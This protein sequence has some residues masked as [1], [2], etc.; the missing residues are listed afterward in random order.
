MNKTSWQSLN[1]HY[2]KTRDR[3]ITSLFDDTARFDDFSVEGVDL[4]LDYSKTN[5][6]TFTKKKLLQLV[7]IKDVPKH[8]NNMFGGSIINVSENRPAL[9]IALRSTS[10]K[11]MVRRKN[12]MPE[13]LKTKER[14][15]NFAEGVRSGIIKSS[16]K[17]RFTDVI[18]IGI[19]GSDLGPRMVTEA[20]KPY[21]DGPRVHYISN[22]DAADLSDTLKD[23]NPE[24]TLVIIASK[25]FKTIETMTNANSVLNWLKSKISAKLQDHLVGISSSLKE[26]EKFGIK[27][28]NVF[29][30]SDWVGGRFSLW[31]PIGLT[32]I[33]AIGS[34]NFQSFLR[35]AEE[36]DGHFHSEIMEKNLPILL[37]LT[38]IWHRNFCG[39][40]TRAL[41]PYEN[42]LSK[43]PAYL[44]QLDMESNGKSISRN[45]KA[46]DINTAP[47]VW[48]EP[49]TNGQHAFYQM[50]HQGTSVVPC[51]FLIGASGHEENLRHQHE[52][53]IANCV[54]QSEALIRGQSYN[55]ALKKNS[56]AIKNKISNK[57]LATQQIFSGNRPSVTIVYPKLTPKVL[58][59]LLSLFEHRTFVEGCIWEVNSF[60]QWGVELGKKLAIDLLP[61]VKNDTDSNMLNSSTRGLLKKIRFFRKNE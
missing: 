59:T 47:I 53:L 29:T 4:L 11:L 20:L 30:F 24:K 23:L 18:N 57:Y 26:T 10:E 54:A 33:L 46:L 40:S 60:D 49:G 17:E 43:L 5:I 1:K 19:G 34:K 55:E 25:T 44:Q 3:K 21:Q 2:Q 15:I 35:G 13:L 32:I 12:I 7:E 8:R 39:Y 38:G 48:G 61:F 9:H 14:M 56:K 52:L 22:V 31:G 41:L 36:M 50:L 27:L 42:R 6:D 16:T 37:A 28:E 45:G 58:G 51:E